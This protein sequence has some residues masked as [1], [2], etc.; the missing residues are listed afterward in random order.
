MAKWAGRFARV[1]FAQIFCQSDFMSE[2]NLGKP[3][4]KMCSLPGSLRTV[5]V[6]KAF[7]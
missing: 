3:F 4:E 6:V 5:A 1:A 7:S 2:T